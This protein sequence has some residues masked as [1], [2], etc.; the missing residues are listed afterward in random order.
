[1]LLPVR[2]D[3]R[4]WRLTRPWEEVGS[5]WQYFEDIFSA[6]VYFWFCPSISCFVFLSNCKSFTYLLKILLLLGSDKGTVTSESVNS[7]I[8]AI[9]FNLKSKKSWNSVNIELFFRFF[10]T[11]AKRRRV[12]T[13]ENVTRKT[14]L[15]AEIAKRRTNQNQGF[16]FWGTAAPSF[17]T[18]LR[19][20]WTKQPS[21]CLK[22]STS[23]STTSTKDFTAPSTRSSQRRNV[24]SS[25]P[26]QT[27]TS[28]NPGNI[29]VGI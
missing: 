4:S 27:Q 23:F 17:P 11:C 13:S 24:L 7:K 19:Q 14:P 8:V 26:A 2:W 29:W 18:P 28:W 12:T 1:M 21:F 3:S 16:K 5:R 22:T 10:Q 25:W 9:S 6:Q 20:S 15:S